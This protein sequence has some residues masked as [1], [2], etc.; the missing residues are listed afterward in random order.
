MTTRQTLG[1]S[2]WLEASPALK[3][4]Y[5][6]EATGWTFFLYKRPLTVMIPLS[7]PL[8]Q[9]LYVKTQFILVQ[10][11][12]HLAYPVNNMSTD[13]KVVFITGGK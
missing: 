8:L 1:E 13:K 12:P 5:K 6:A 11:T 3:R 10:Y 9:S 4:A 2:M 7:N